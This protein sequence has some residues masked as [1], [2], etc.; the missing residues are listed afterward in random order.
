LKDL[1][2]EQTRLAKAEEARLK[3]VAKAEKSLQ[4]RLAVL[5]KALWGRSYVGI[6]GTKRPAANYADFEVTEA[7]A[8]PKNIKK[9]K[10]N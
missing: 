4:V 8:S 3:S 1:K 2:T 7:P 6:V 9:M 5:E 10:K